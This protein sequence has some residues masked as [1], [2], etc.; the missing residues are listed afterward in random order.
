MFVATH[1]SLSLWIESTI[2]SRIIQS[3]DEKEKQQQ[4]QVVGIIVPVDAS[5]CQEILSV[6]SV[7]WNRKSVVLDNYNYMH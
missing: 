3:H 2:I 6:L 5:S 4:T 7:V 1:R